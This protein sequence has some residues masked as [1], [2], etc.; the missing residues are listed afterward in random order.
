VPAPVDLRLALS[1]WGKAG[2]AGEQFGSH[3]AVWHMIDV[4]AVAERLLAHTPLGAGVERELWRLF[5]F[6]V[7]CHDV[8][9]LS[10]SFQAIR[11]D[12]APQVLGPVDSPPRIHHVDVG[13]ALLDDQDL[14]DDVLSPWLPGWTTD[15]LRPLASAVV[16]HHGRPPVR[17][18]ELPPGVVCST[19]RRAVRAAVALFAELTGVVPVPCI[20]SA[21]IRRLSWQLAALTNLADWI[22][23][24]DSFRYAPPD[25]DPEAYW[26]R[27][28][29]L[30]DEALAT[31]GVLPPRASRATGAAVL[32]PAIAVPRPMQA[33]AETVALP[34]DGPMLAV[35]EDS[36]GS[37]KTEAALI[38]A[39]RLIAA[40]RASGVYVAMPT[41]ATANAMHSRL[42]GVY[43]RMFAPGA[44]PSLVLAHGRRSLSDDF[45][46]SVLEGLAHR[47]DGEE[48]AGP[49]CAAWI[50]DDR[51]K[52]FLAA[53]GVGTVDQAFLAVLPVR[54]AALRLAGLCGKVLVIDEAHAYDPYMRSELGALIR[55]HASL[56]G[57]VVVLSAT[58]TLAQRS[59]LVAA[60]ADGAGIVLP[61]PAA[62]GYPLATVAGS[63]GLMEQEVPPVPAAR[64]RRVAVHRI[65]DVDGIVRE[66]RTAHST[67]AAAAWVR[68]TVDDVMAGAAALEAAGVP[69]VVFHARF[70][71][72]DRLAIEDAVVRRFGAASADRRGPVLVASQVIEQSL[73][74]DFDLLA[75][76]LAPIDL[77]IQRA[78]RLWRHERSGRPLP[79][80]RLL[81]LSP[82]PVEDPGADWLSGPFAGSL[83]VYR[84][85]AL[86]WR[87][88]RELS[89]RG[90]VPGPCG[91]RAAIEAVY[92]PG[93]EVPAGL[94]GRSLK[95]EGE[96]TGQGQLGELN[97]LKLDAGYMPGSGGWTADH[98]FPTRLGEPS[99]TVRLASWAGGL[100]LPWCDGPDRGRAW[101]LSEVALRCASFA[102]AAVPPEAKDAIAAEIAGWPE[103]DRGIPILILIQDG[104]GTAVGE[105]KDRS[106]RQRT[107]RYDRTTGMQ[108]S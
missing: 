50:A 66:L 29:R 101:A 8:G 57:S 68:N 75:T 5:V 69:T 60:F 27:A 91:L 11:P 84:D 90:H 82:D 4:A 89:G 64:T 95:A 17:S 3:P 106:G 23:S 97:V 88:A 72:G 52:A 58:L 71:M 46:S 14:L 65:G 48:P 20:T 26:T 54:H 10:R 61:S 24:G 21:R 43:R 31:T 19:C 49:E 108:F 105:V 36:T 32:F 81:L 83:A 47:E 98:L 104:D 107:A 9:K 51:R 79:D 13:A 86:L 76:D 63:R 55:F 2:R 18:R 53:V 37:G 15:L 16:G 34:P 25:L 39:Q 73:D 67:G 56:G 40:G 96:S 85:P 30:A 92:G 103:R 35:I 28:L 87:S 70:A 12:L 41:M 59:D 38:L 100:L 45:A 7:A 102:E 6:L 80:P 74:L 33:W 78:G 62:A 44:Q 94:E 1:F 77:V 22:G 93:V 99:V 42:A